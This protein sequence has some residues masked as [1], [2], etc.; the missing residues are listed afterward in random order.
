MSYIEKIVNK[1]ST[2]FW[3]VQVTLA[4]DTIINKT[5]VIILSHVLVYSKF[6]ISLEK[7][8]P[9]LSVLVQKMSACNIC[10]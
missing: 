9:V 8:I 10:K 7:S 2:Y 1:C 5:F 6:N 3:Q 4:G